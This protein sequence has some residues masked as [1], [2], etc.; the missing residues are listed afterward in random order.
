MKKLTILAPLVLAIPTTAYSTDAKT[1]VQ[2]LKASGFVDVVYV[3][4]DGSDEFKNADDKSEADKKFSV[5]GELDVE[6][7]L[8]P[9][10]TLRMDLDLT[11]GYS[12]DTNPLLSTSDSASFEQ[13]FVNYA[14]EQNMNLKMGVFNNRLGF[15]REDAPELYQISHS[16]LWAIWDEQTS[17][18][19]GNNL[20]GVEFSANVG[21]V[22]LIAG[23][24]N[25]I[26]AEPE[27][28]SFKLA[29]EVKPSES[30][31]IVAGLISADSGENT[32][33]AAGTFVDDQAGTII[34]AAITWKWNQLMLGGGLLTAE[35]MYD[36]G[37][38]ATANYAFTDNLS[39]TARI[40]YVKYEGD[41]DNSTSLTLAALFSAAENLYF[42]AEIRAMQNDNAAGATKADGTSDENPYRKTGDGSMVF[43]EVIGTF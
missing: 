37:L 26:N 15:E 30:L 11:T 33:N 35:E 2:N 22:T 12:P 36:L 34:D 42:N 19:N 10:T 28:I 8:N 23:L 17:T 27:K 18:L 5:K 40:D 43:L 21:M 4:S 16:Q 25:D 6:T 29:A 38:Q 24:L 20:A 1:V 41:Y 7:E 13:A 39:G 14:F 31:D 3:L 32:H 9:R